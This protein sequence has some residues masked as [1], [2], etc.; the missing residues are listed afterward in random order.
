MKQT[1]SS[2]NLLLKSAFEWIF[3]VMQLILVKIKWHIKWKYLIQ[4]FHNIC[5]SYY[6]KH[7]IN[8]VFQGPQLLQKKIAYGIRPSKI[9]FSVT[10]DGRNLIFGHKRHIGIPYCG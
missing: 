2:I 10:I 9:F 5:L 3:N 8:K 1:D 4:K 7:A 6:F